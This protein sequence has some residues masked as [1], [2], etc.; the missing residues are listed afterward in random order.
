[1]RDL[2][3]LFIYFI[4]CICCS[5]LVAHLVHR[6]V[7]IMAHGGHNEPSPIQPIPINLI[8]WP[9][10]PLSALGLG[11]VKRETHK[12]LSFSVINKHHPLQRLLPLSC[13]V[14]RQNKGGLNGHKG[15]SRPRWSFQA[16]IGRTVQHLPD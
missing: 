12:R 11:T 13:S 4:S 14:I 2:H 9:R 10:I 16:S 6:L 7:R 15:L 8:W 3:I 1:M 5:L